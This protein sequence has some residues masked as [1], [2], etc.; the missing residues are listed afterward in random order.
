MA[1]YSFIYSRPITAVI[2]QHG[3]SHIWYLSINSAGDAELTIFG[4]GD[5]IRHRF[6]IA[7]R[8]LMELRNALVEQDFFGLA[9]T[10]GEL[11]PDG[12]SDAITIVFGQRSK[13]VEI[14]FL[15]NW[16]NEAPHRLKEPSRAIRILLL[17]HAWL[18]DFEE[19]GIDRGRQQYE[20]V[21]DAME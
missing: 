12:S 4:I 2:S 19:L 16:V 13:T 10:Y 11:V 8:Q 9:D 5:P 18:N 3:G 20:M 14:H 17:T 21:L 7:E 1:E 15:M 6:V